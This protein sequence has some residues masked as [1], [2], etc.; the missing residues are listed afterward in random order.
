MAEL[1]YRE[2][3][4]HALFE[5]MRRDPLVFVMGEGIAERGGSYKVTEGLLKEFGPGRVMDTP[6]SEA[7]FTGC[8]VG[9]ALV[10]T[11]PVVEILFVDFTGL[12]MDQI[13]NQAAKYEFMSGGQGKVPMVLRTQGGAGNG[14][15]GQHSQSLEALFYHIPGLKVVMPSTPYDA[16]GLLKASIRDDDPTIFIEHKLLYM[17][18]GEVPED[19]YI[20]PL[21]QANIKR[22]GDDITLVTY[23]YMTLKCLEAAEVLAQEGISVEVVDLRTLTPLDKET[24]LE[25]V[26]KTGR[27]IVVHE[28]VKRGG[29]GGDIASVI[30]EEAYD[31]LDGPVKRICGKNTTVPYNLDLEKVCVP[32]VEEIIEGI[33]E[34]V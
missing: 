22:P 21:G 19:D 17:T 12:I 2:A 6:I 11:R 5:E 25:S 14:L 15:A 30:M 34:M 26:E 24:V 16:K 33:L 8:G 27:A 23:S 1:M 32:T 10:G 3:L 7:S 4:N 9:A 18:K 29:V 20:V 31:D 28:A 13:I